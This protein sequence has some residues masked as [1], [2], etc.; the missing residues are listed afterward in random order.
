MLQHEFEDGLRAI[1][2]FNMRD[3]ETAG[4]IEQ[5]DSGAWVDFTRNPYRWVSH[6]S[7]ARSE[8]MWALIEQSLPVRS[9]GEESADAFHE[10]FQLAQEHGWDGIV[11]LWTWLRNRLYAYDRYDQ[12]VVELLEANNDYLQ[13]ARD[14]RADAKSWKHEFEMYAKA[15][16]RE[17]GKI[18]NKAHRIDALVKTTRFV[19]ERAARADHLERV[20][21]EKRSGI[22]V[23]SKVRHAPTWKTIR[24]SGL[25]I[26]STW[27]DEA[28]QGES[29]DLTDL[30][31][32][33]IMEA[34]TAE[35]LI[36]YR[37]PDEALKGAWA[38]VGAALACG[39]PV[40]AVGISEFT[41]ANAKGIT[42]FPNL[43]AAIDAARNLVAVAA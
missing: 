41:I 2:S 31:R 42:H 33:C 39:V 18:F 40:Y 9:A 1:T 35:V 27:I 13:Q 21:A 29:G 17:L 10:I 28:G 20:M 38:E 23:A 36:V 37:L 19:V 3:L 32:R 8:K 6:L 15:W 12:R 11:S 5:G 22:Y 16:T 24:A 4:V 26:I 43:D 30:W 34:S 14:A 25:P 7:P